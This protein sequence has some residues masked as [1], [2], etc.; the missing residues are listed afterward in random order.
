MLYGRVGIITSMNTVSR[1]FSA[2]R[3]ILIKDFRRAQFRILI[4]FIITLVAARLLVHFF[5]G[6]FASV[7]GTHV[8][9][10]T[11]GIVLLAIAG[12]LSQIG[13]GQPPALLNYTY[14]VGLALAFDEFGMWLHLTS[15]YN[16][17]QTTDIIIF[18][19]SFLVLITFFS[20]L[21][22]AGLRRVL[23]FGKK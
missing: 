10:F 20:D 1:L 18:L 14:G 12:Y 13:A 22:V 8:H 11:Y 9:H 3:K 7:H 17:D 19:A 21:L 2:R 15:D 6:L 5:P 23:R 4:A 16:L